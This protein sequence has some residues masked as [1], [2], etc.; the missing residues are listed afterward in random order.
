MK[1]CDALRDM[2]VTPLR[3]VADLEEKIK[4]YKCIIPK[5]VAFTPTFVPT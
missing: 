1:N 4:N 2:I 5:V 3:R